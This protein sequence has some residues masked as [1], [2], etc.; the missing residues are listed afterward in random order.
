MSVKNLLVYSLLTNVVLMGAVMWQEQLRADAIRDQ[1]VQALDEDVI[2]REHVVR[3]L[4][5]ENPERIAE[6][7]RLCRAELAEMRPQVRTIWDP[8]E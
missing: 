2:F 5:S 6:V 3:E 1:Q 4:A 8:V 7:Q